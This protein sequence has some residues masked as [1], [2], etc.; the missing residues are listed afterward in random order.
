MNHEYK[1]NVYEK[2][3]NSWQAGLCGLGFLSPNACKRVILMSKDE[4]GS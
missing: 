4:S 2:A 3:P 1:K